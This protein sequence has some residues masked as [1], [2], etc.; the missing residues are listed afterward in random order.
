MFISRCWFRQA[1]N[2]WASVTGKVEA[3]MPLGPHKQ[4]HTHKTVH[5]LAWFIQSHTLSMDTWGPQQCT[6][7]I[8]EIQGCNIFIKEKGVE[9]SPTSLHGDQRFQTPFLPMTLI[10]LILWSLIEILHEICKERRRGFSKTISDLHVGNSKGLQRLNTWRKY[11]IYEE[12]FNQCEWRLKANLY[13]SRTYA[14]AT[15]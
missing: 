1:P 12:T 3:K 4:T 10:C 8:Q 6:K 5:E 7:K 13:K 14:V 15:S 11:K 9:K 2:E